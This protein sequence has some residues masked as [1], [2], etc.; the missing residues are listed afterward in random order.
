MDLL[1]ITDASKKFD[2]SSK[3]LRYYENVGVLRPIR[4]EG[5][6]YR[7]YDDEAVE[8]IKQILILRKMQISIK[9]IIRIY[10]NEE[11]STV[12]EI[13]VDRINT[14]DEQ[15]SA[16]SELKR[17]INEFLQTMTRNGI[18]KI[19]AIPLLYEEMDKHLEVL[20]QHKSITY[21]ELSTV[22]EKLQKDIDISIVELP[23][24]RML[25]SNRKD[26]SLSDL[27]G[28]TNWLVQN[29][30]A[31]SLPGSHELFEY[32]EDKGDTVLLRKINTS[33]ENISPFIDIHFDGGLFAVYSLFVDEDIAMA[34]KKVIHSFDGNK[35]YKI[36]YQHD[37]KLRHDSLIEN[38]LS[39]DVQREK[40]N[41]YIAVKTRLPDVSL[42]ESG[43]RIENI[44]FEEI[45]AANPILWTKEFPIDGEIEHFHL[46]TEIKVQYPFRV[47][48][49]FRIG[50][51]RIPQYSGAGRIIPSVLFE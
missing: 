19:S 8:R 15:V 46:A 41:V 39:P 44:S 47:D 14:I 51:E 24:M 20:E 4:M 33:F 38:I 1:C 26:S 17:I 50:D 3:T 32:Q 7:Y 28:F 12:V 10:E 9:D 21:K 6:K 43:E 40:I 35:Y 49:E 42:Y 23:P 16:L 27:E 29:N 2:V 11:M 36:D 18:T 25:S 30:I 31:R 34:Y 22:S 37:G 13:F 5:N 48:I 45:E